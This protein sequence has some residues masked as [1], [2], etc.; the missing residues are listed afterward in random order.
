[1]LN[2]MQV[3]CPNC[4][5][6]FNIDATA[7]DLV[8]QQMR[9][10]QCHYLWR[11]QAN[12]SLLLTRPLDYAKIKSREEVASW[13]SSI[14][15]R[16]ILFFIIITISC[17]ALFLR[18]QQ[19]HEITGI[20]NS[21]LKVTMMSVERQ[22]D[23]IIVSYYLYN[24][25]DSPQIMPAM[26]VKLIDE[27]GQIMKTHPINENRQLLAKRTWR[28]DVTFLTTKYQVKKATVYLEGQLVCQMAC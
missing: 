15:F 6:S 9:C 17:A 14:R 22:A 26:Q 10:S 12:H 18:P 13:N 20:N 5:T 7:I 28:I 19:K 24:L 21:L 27:Q 4:H 25:S 8:D 1:M 16:H 23:K 2:S 11:Q 3:I